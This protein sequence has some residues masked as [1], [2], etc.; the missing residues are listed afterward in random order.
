MN[1]VSFYKSRFIDNRTFYTGYRL[2][3]SKQVL[4]IVNTEF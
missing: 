1:K 4:K 2:Q 3:V